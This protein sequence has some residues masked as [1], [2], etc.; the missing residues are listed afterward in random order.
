MNV[1]EVFS[2]TGSV[3][4]ICDELGWNVVSVDNEFEATHKCDIMTWDYRQYPQ[5]HFQVIWGSPPCHTF[6]HLQLSWIGR[7]MRGELITRDKVI[8]RQEKEGLPLLYKLLEIIDYFS[9]KFYF[10]ENP[11]TS[12]MKDYLDLPNYVVDYCKYCDWGYRKRTRIWT[13]VKTFEPKVCKR[14]CENMV[15]TKKTVSTGEKGNHIGNVSGGKNYKKMGTGAHRNI[16]ENVSKH[17]TYRI[18]PELIRDLFMC[19][20]DEY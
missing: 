11:A 1:L 20:I 12:R 3:G 9:P 4:K 2:G 14:D 17:H 10:I 18:P 8:E 6:S 15:F 5:D 16:V 13:N 7:K 19:V